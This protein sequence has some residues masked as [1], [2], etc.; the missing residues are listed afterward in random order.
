MAG[1]QIKNMARTQLSPQTLQAEQIEKESRALNDDL[2]L[3]PGT[4]IRGNPPSLFP[5]GGTSLLEALKMRGTY[6]WRWI[7]SRTMDR[8][9]RIYYWAR[10]TNWP[11]KKKPRFRRREAQNAAM[12]NYERMYKAFAINDLKELN[13]VCISG[14]VFDLQKRIS[15]RPKNTT[16]KWE[17]IKRDRS[18]RIVSNRAT[19]I[20]LPGESNNRTTPTAVRQIVVL[21][22]TKQRLTINRTDIKLAAGKTHKAAS[23]TQ[24]LGWQPLA[25]KQD[26]EAALLKEE[27]E[28][29]AL[30]TAPVE[31]TVA[32]YVVLQQRMLRGVEEGWKIWGFVKPSTLE[33]I[34]KG[35]QFED[36][37]AAYQASNPGLV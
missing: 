12:D 13:K 20:P 7:K 33:S 24:S 29:E 22:K 11:W 32:E 18:P 26:Q 15:T 37:Y 9:G 25:A 16:L 30:Q 31:K 35:D 1:Q 27:A 36:D 23:R 17:I 19:Q 3:L 34:A 21:M 28:L 6:E 10:L 5:S 2:G 14:I 8:I 4:F